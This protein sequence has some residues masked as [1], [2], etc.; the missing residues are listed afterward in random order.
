M[1]DLHRLVQEGYY[2]KQAGGSIS[3]KTVLP[4]ILNDAEE[5]AMIYRHPGVYGKG[6]A[7]ESLN[8]G[9]SDGHVWLQAEKGNDPY[10]TLP[11]IFGTEHGKL[12]EMLDRLA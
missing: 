2:S 5:V 4:S 10:K 7:I 12:N 11:A 1:V 9:G 8:F 6:L 3:L